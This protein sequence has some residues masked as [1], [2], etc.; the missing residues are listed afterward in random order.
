MSCLGRPLANVVTSLVPGS[1]REIRPAKVSGT[2]SA[3][4]GP[5]VLPEPPSRPPTSKVTVG[6]LGV[7]GVMDVAF[8]GDT[9][10]ALVTLVGSDWG[11]SD[12][13]GI[14]R[15]DGPNSFTVV[16]DIGKWA[17]AH[18]KNLPFP[19]D[20]PTGVQY[21]MQPYRG[22]FLVTDGHHNRVLWVTL[23]GEITQVIAFGNIVPTGL[24]VRGNTIYIAEAGPAP[25]EPKDSKVMSFT[26]KSSTAMQVASGTGLNKIGLLVDVEF[27]RGNTLYALAQ[28][29]WHG[30]YEGAPADP[31]SGALL[32]VNRDGTFSVIVEGL[33]QP[34]SFEF[35]GNT[36]YVVTLTG[37]IWKIDNVSPPPYG[38]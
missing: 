19:I 8:I 14:Y 7:G 15:V 27:G 26:L 17:T 6:S 35:I 11:G 12:I 38:K 2:Y 3:P 31:N 21:A 37:E 33:N 30:A 20:T 36:A 28:G 4:S 34:T 24:D 10:Y 25:H 23:D 32:K 22:G 9:A 29:D 18:S 5:I 13:V 1:T 16:A